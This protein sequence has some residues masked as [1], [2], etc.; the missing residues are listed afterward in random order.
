MNRNKNI[1]VNYN[2]QHEFHIS[3]WWARTSGWTP[4]AR[5]RIC[6]CR[7]SF[8]MTFVQS[9]MPPRLCLPCS[10]QN[11]TCGRKLEKLLTS[12]RGNPR[13]INQTGKG[14]TTE[15]KGAVTKTKTQCSPRKTIQLCQSVKTTFSIL[16][17]LLF[18]LS[19]KTRSLFFKTDRKFTEIQKKFS[20]AINILALSQNKSLIQLIKGGKKRKA[21]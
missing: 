6:V 5:Y 4:E 18:C 13:Y 8:L 17:P 12:L 2:K 11:V 14:Y 1:K 21:S 10:F 7:A 15:R 16:C 9:G 20:Y 19:R 3:L